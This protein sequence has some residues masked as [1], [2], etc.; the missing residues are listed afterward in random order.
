MANTTLTVESL[1]QLMKLTQRKEQ[2]L[3]EIE[4]VED[5]IKGA[6]GGKTPRGPK[7]TPAKRAGKTAAKPR[8]RKRRGSLGKKILAALEAAGAK[9]VKVADLAKQIG[10]KGPNLHVWFATTG[11][12]HTKKVGRGH[13]KLAK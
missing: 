11:K 12:K 3:K 1:K 10:A 2:L 13:Y 7:A 4:K 6:L 8:G 5:M 9:G